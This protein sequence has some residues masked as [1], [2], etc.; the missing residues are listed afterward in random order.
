MLG[1]K[2]S[3]NLAMSTIVMVIIG[4]VM[5]TSGILL[6]QSF[7]TGAE[8]IKTQLDAQTESELERL[9]IDA[10]KKVALPLHT[11]QLEAGEDHIFGVG[12]LNIDYSLYGDQFWI[13]ITLSKLLDEEDVE[14]E[15][16]ND[17]KALSWF[18]YNTEKITIQENQHMSEALYIGVPEDAP[19]G[20]YIYNVYVYYQP[21]GGNEARYDSVKKLYVVVD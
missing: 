19:K 9:M 7:I 2:A 11:V 3:I 4:M 8:D 21:K 12:I 10:G 5:L 13:D 17:L 6:M 16:V 14:V 15:D 20:T 1:K 18:L